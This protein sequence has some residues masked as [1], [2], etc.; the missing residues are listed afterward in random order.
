MLLHLT[1]YECDMWHMDVTQVLH[2]TELNLE[3]W[4]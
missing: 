3:A 2:A 4:D 1:K